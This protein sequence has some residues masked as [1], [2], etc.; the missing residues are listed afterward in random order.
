M[1]DTVD[2]NSLI[3]KGIKC[4]GKIG[5]APFVAISVFK[6]HGFGLTQNSMVFNIA[7]NMEQI[8]LT[9]VLACIAIV[10]AVFRNSIHIIEAGGIAA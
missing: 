6:H 4:F 1:I 9:T 7:C 5:Q 10:H 3:L 8:T 2:V